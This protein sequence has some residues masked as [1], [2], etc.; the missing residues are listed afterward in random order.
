MAPEF[1]ITPE[2]QSSFL[3]FWREQIFF[4]PAEVRDVSLL[5]KTAIVTGSNSGI[6]YQVCLQLLDLGLS[7][8]IIAVRSEEKGKDAAARLSVG[9]PLAKDTIEVWLLD[10]SS[11]ESVAS[12]AQRAQSLERLDIV[13]L[14]IGI[15]PTERRF[16]KNTGHDEVIQVNYLSTALLAILLLPVVKEKRVNQPQPSRITFTSSEVAG[17]TKFKERTTTEPLL[18]T[19]DRKEGKVSMTDR[20]F[21]S[22]LLGQFFLARLAA[23][24]PPSIALI[25]GA[26]PAAVYDSEFGRDFDK[27]FIGAAY[28]MLLRCLANS[29]AVGARMMTDAIVNHGEET[30]GKFLS[31]QKVVPM[32]PIIYTEEGK[33]I[34]EKLWKETMAELSFAGA[35]NILKTVNE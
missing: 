3:H 23:E 14:N 25:N 12:F 18:S 16:N 8:L 30:H 19:F 33:S 34:S 5:G 17:W 31:F 26:S 4:K 6:G 28:K 13:N 15:G 1:D 32:A 22:K 11:Y 29:S 10:Q 7:K 21:V 20:M 2:K 27:T 9:R 35:E 24:V